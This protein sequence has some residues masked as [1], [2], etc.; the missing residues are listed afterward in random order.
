[1]PKGANE[2]TAF[3]PDAAQGMSGP[4]GELP[5]IA[6]AKVRQLVL[7]PVAPQV[8]YGV[9]FWGIS[10]EAFHPDFAMKTF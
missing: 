10:W 5:E 8:L 7:F 4:A 2:P 3:T 9:E 1:M 6:G